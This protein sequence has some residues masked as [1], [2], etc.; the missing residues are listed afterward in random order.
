MHLNGPHSQPACIFI[1]VAKFLVLSFNKRKYLLKLP[2]AYIV[3]KNV[4]RR[5]SLKENHTRCA[6][7]ISNANC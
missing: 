2:N 5:K 3:L 6:V 1:K 7:P 4:L